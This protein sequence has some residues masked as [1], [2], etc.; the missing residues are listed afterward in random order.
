MVAEFPKTSWKVSTPREMALES[1]SL[2][3]V[4]DCAKWTGSWSFLHLEMAQSCERACWSLTPVKH[5]EFLLLGCAEQ[6][7]SHRIRGQDC[8]HKLRESEH[9]SVEHVKGRGVNKEIQRSRA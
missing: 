6:F 1:A 3:S 4:S 7:R 5:T 2:E 8:G 9:S